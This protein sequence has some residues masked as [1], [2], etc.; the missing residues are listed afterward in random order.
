M[1]MK[2]LANL[3]RQDS[4]HPFVGPEPAFAISTNVAGGVIRDWI[5]KNMRSVASL[6]MDK[7]RLWAILKKSITS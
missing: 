2:S 7:G 4:V 3:T 6:F 5:S 1:E